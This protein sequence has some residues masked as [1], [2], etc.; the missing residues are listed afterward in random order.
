MDTSD[1]LTIDTPEQVALELPIA[2]VGSRFLAVAADTVVQVL[3]ALLG[4]LAVLGLSQF[5][6]AGFLAIGPA[7]LVLFGFALYWGYFTF[8]EILWK[9]QTPGK[10]LAG[11]RV[12]K[13]SGRPVDAAST[14]VR[15]LLRAID[16]LPGM[17]AAGV[18]CM[19]LNRHSRRVGDFVAGTV[20]IHD[21][22]DAAV[23]DAWETPSRQPRFAST[24]S[25]A[26]TSDELV[27][28]ETY[29]ARRHD[30][31]G[32]IRDAMA[33]RILEMLEARHNLTPDPGHDVDA[34]LAETARSARETARMRT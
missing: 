29:L 23:A 32:H 34:F 11:V 31:P 25:A 4:L 16:L 6:A 2:G 18:V 20:V 30:A 19:M 8:F 5:G 9:G 26:L 1:Q 15:N 24:I 13:M 27:L 33:K 21:R 10:R 22:P 7:L 28:I 17:Y 12:I 3:L 14:I